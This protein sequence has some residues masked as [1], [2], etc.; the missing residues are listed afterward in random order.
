[1]MKNRILKNWSIIRVVYV[2]LG[3]MILVQTVMNREW[4]GVLIG[5]YFVIMGLFSIGCASGNCAID[6]SKN[7]VQTNKNN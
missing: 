7:P 5:A 1:M 3:T 4:L 2:I 6:S